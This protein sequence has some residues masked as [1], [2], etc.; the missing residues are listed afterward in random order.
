MKRSWNGKTEVAKA[1]KHLDWYSAKFNAFGN[2]ELVADNEPPVIMAIFTIM[3]TFL[4]LRR[5]LLLQKIIM[6]R[7]KISGQNW[8]EN[9]CGLPMIK[10]KT[11]SIILMKNAQQENMN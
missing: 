8:M 2:F 7:S 5:L 1:M 3:P 6:T 11:L 4:K 10:G 9:G